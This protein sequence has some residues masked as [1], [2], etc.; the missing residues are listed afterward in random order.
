MFKPKALFFVSEFFHQ[1]LCLFPVR[2]ITGCIFQKCPKMFYIFRKTEIWEVS[3][4]Y[5]G[6]FAG[7]ELNRYS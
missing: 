3:D 2:K 5:D 4:S 1:L 7:P 6:K